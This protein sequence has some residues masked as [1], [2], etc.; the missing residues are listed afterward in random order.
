MQE[1]CGRICSD[2]GGMPVG[3]M[4]KTTMLIMLSNEG[5]KIFPEFKNSALVGHSMRVGYCP[6]VSGFRD[7]HTTI[8]RI[9]SM[10]EHI[11]QKIPFPYKT[12]PKCIAV[13]RL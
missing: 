8:V 10:P 3:I 4:E 11:E 7:Q 5:E 9:Q 12:D 1:L 2:E 13:F 6:F